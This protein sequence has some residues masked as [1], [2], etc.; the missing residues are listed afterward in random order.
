MVIVP[1]EFPKETKEKI[2]NALKE[3]GALNNPCPRCRSKNFTLLDGYLNNQVQM[4]LG[5]VF[6]GGPSV[7]SVVVVCSQCGYMSQHAIG[8]LGLLREGGE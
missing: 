4:G 3:K 7:P 2:I 5:N 8:V 6:F 1:N